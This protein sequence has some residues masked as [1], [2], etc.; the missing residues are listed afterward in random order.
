M[1]CRTHNHNVLPRS[2][3]AHVLQYSCFMVTGVTLAT[4]CLLLGYFIPKSDAMS[5]CYRTGGKWLLLMLT[6]A[7]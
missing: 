6:N 3:P 7:V 5:F 2:L 1:D 4:E